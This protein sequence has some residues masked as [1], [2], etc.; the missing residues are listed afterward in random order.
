MDEANIDTRIGIVTTVLEAF[1][2]QDLDS[3]LAH[4]AP[5]IEWH[6]HVGTQPVVGRDTMAKVL[7]KLGAHQRDSRWRAIRWAETGNTLLIEGVEDYLNPD[8]RRAQVPYMGAYEFD[9]DNRI[10]AWRDY[11]DLALLMKSD[12]GEPMDAWVAALIEAEPDD[13]SSDQ[14]AVPDR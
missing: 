10:V 12:R 8:D 13:G 11:F 9:E 1:G 4:I 7:A 6:Y 2:R 14:R 3:V 5:D